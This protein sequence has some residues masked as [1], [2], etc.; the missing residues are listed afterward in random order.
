MNILFSESALFFREMNMFF[1]GAWVGAAAV[2]G[3]A[4]IRKDRNLYIG[5]CV[6]FML[7]IVAWSVT[8]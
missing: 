8:L 1:L 7:N 4:I 5:A 2:I 6:W 3:F